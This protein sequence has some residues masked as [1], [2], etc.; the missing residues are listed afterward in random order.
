MNEASA[1]ISATGWTLSAGTAS[2]SSEL[3][4]LRGFQLV[5]FPPESPPLRY[6]PIEFAIY[7]VMIN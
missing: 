2:I 7:S 5:L 1:G 4:L 6:N 3:P